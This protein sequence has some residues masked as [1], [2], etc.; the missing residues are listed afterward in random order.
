MTIINISGAPCTGKSLFAARFILEHP[1]FKYFPIDEYRIT[2]KD[3]ALAWD[4]LTKDVLIKHRCLIESCGMGWR[5]GRLLNLPEIRKRPLLTIAFTGERRILR[6]RLE[7]RHKR[8]LPEPFSKEDE[9]LAL[10]YTIEHFYEEIES[11]LDYVIDTSDISPSQVYDQVN[12]VIQRELLLNNSQ[13]RKIRRKYPSIHP[14]RM[15]QTTRAKQ[16]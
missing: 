10:D 1:Q 6:Q 9:I 14:G 7:E 3:E 13:G 11:S 12:R 16:L 8:P 5:L 2:F 4:K 15:E